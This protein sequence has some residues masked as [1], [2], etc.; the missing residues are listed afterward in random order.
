MPGFVNIPGRLI[1]SEQKGGVVDLGKRGSEGE[2]TGR[3]SGRGNCGPD[4]NM[5]EKNA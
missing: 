3:R 4:V 5:C 2:G 1:I